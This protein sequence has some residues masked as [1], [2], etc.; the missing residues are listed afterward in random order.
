MRVIETS[1]TSFFP[2][3]TFLVPQPED[4][5]LD[6]YLALRDNA[7][8]QVQSEQFLDELDKKWASQKGGPGE[9]VLRAHVMELKAFTLAQEV[10]RATANDAAETKK[11]LSNSLGRASIAVGSTKE[12]LAES[13]W[14]VKGAVTL[15]KE[16]I[17]VFSGKDRAEPTRAS[18]SESS[19]LT[20]STICCRSESE[21]SSAGRLVSS[22]SPIP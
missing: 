10:A 16:V 14:Y 4:R 11:W 21:S 9:E 20:R 2:A 19:R 7:L 3:Q 5:P 8:A 6:Q 17:D 13:P 15:L 1:F 22:A 18:S 12:L